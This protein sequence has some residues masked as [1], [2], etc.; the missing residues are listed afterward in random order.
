VEAREE[1]SPHIELAALLARCCEE[2]LASLTSETV[3]SVDAPMVSKTVVS[4][5]DLRGA[6]IGATLVARFE[7]GFLGR[8][9][10][11]RHRR[12]TEED[13][14]G[15]ASEIV[16]QVGGRFV[17]KLGQRGV[18]AQIGIPGS[19]LGPT[20]HLHLPPG[21]GEAFARGGLSLFLALDELRRPLMSVAQDDATRQEGD[22]V[23]F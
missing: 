3:A 16:N 1:G 11:R 7:E 9:H 15:W 10:P 21:A 5:I 23:L 12:L 2:L 20:L 6:D 17:N 18:N 13:L 4:F 19:L 14:A 22:L 8:T